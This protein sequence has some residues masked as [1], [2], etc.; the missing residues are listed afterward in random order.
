M[1]WLHECY[2]SSQRN[3]SV[4]VSSKQRQG[5]YWSRPLCSTYIRCL[6]PALTESCSAC[7]KSARV[8]LQATRWRHPRA[9]RAPR[10]SLA[11][12]NTEGTPPSGR[13]AW[14][15][16]VNTVM[17]V[18]HTDIA[19]FKYAPTYASRGSPNSEHNRYMHFRVQM[20]A[21]KLHTRHC[22]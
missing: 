15:H 13:S 19:S 12:A 22:N 11:R 6:T 17:I 16:L 9:P 20:G 8:R 21:H 10:Q 5:R 18:T 1:P 2:F 3:L 14:P 7:G 4:R